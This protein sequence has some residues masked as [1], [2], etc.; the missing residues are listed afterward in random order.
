[1]PLTGC[2]DDE[3][4]IEEPADEDEDDDEEDSAALTDYLA[5]YLVSNLC[6]IDSVGD[7]EV[8]SPRYGKAL[9]EG[10]PT[11][12]SC[13]MKDEYD[14]S[15]FFLNNIVN[16]ELGA[17]FLTDNG[18]AKVYDLGKNGSVTYK[19]SAQPGEIAV[20]TFDMPRVEK[21]IK[22]LTIVPTDAWPENNTSPFAVGDVLCET[23]GG[24]NY[25]WL[26]VREYQGGV[27]GILMTVDTG[28]SI[29][30][31]SDHYKSFDSFRGCAGKDAWDAL[32]QWWFDDEQDFRDELEGIKYYEKTK[33]GGK[34]Y[35][36]IKDIFTRVIDGSKSWNRIEYQY[37]DTW[38][39]KYYWWAK[40][41]NVWEASTN[42]VVLGKRDND[43]TT[44][45]STRNYY[46]KRDWTPTFPYYRNSSSRYFQ[47]NQNNQLYNQYKIVYPEL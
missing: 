36:W 31:R 21:A 46:F 1:M 39:N 5:Y 35:G 7:T 40:V 43:R 26:C 11:D 19:V 32:S 29:I 45:F 33:N 17:D 13:A 3:P 23:I 20:I 4:V 24:K 14:A 27:D 34:P 44:K 42:A 37:G 9:N 10:L 6:S 47:S 25:Y 12:L 41:R 38:D 28:W 8:L 15:D 22:T 30:K 18:T 16:S 2:S